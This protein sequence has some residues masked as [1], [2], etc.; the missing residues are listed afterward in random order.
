MSKTPPHNSA[1]AVPPF[2]PAAFQQRMVLSQLTHRVGVGL[3]VLSFALVFVFPMFGFTTADPAVALLAVAIVPGIWLPIAFTTAKTARQLP[4]IGALIHP[5]PDRAEQRLAEALRRRPVM[6]PTRLLLYHRLATLRHRQRRFDE[7]AAICQQLLY[8]PLVGPAAGARPSLL[9]MLTE[10]LL[11]QRNLA[12]A[13]ESLDALH[14]TRLGLA[15]AIQR[16]AL[17]TRYALLAGHHDHALEHGR[18]KVELA[19]LMPPPQ[20][21]AMHA[22]LATAAQRAGRQQLAQWL[23][24][25]TELLTPPALLDQLRQGAFEVEVV[26]GEEEA[27]L[28][29]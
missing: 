11:V 28:A 19:E 17:Q 22:M 1:D 27:D 10:C 21:G 14:R 12:G 9:L 16:L 13:Y 29:T 2:D 18:R 8:Q 15:G 6:R 4:E 20:C 23:W 25:R 7:A 26:A 3:T 5:H 24:Q